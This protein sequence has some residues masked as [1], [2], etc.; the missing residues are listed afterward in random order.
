MSFLSDFDPTFV[1]SAPALEGLSGKELMFAIDPQVFLDNYINR[2]LQEYRLNS[3]ETKKREMER[4]Y[5]EDPRPSFTVDPNKLDLR[6]FRN[7]NVPADSYED[8]ERDK[9]L[10]SMYSP[11]V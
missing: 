8:V 2:G 7:P 1:N 6:E 5:M 4:I 3:P 9:F 11:L 10:K